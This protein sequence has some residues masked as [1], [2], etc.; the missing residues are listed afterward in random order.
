MTQISI[1]SEPVKLGSYAAPVAQ[2]LDRWIFVI[3][4]A[5]YIVV[6]LVGFIPDSLDQIA[7]VEAGKRPPFPP[8]LHAH[9]VLMGSFLLLLFGQSFLAATGRRAAHRKLGIAGAILALAL[10]VVG[11]LL[12][13]TMYHSLWDATQAMP[14]AARAELQQGLRDFENII[15]LQIRIG[16]LFPAFFILALAARKRDSGLHKR[17]MFL[18]VAMALPAAFDR[19]QWLPT[20]LPGG[21]LTTDLYPLLALA[22]MFVWDVVRTRKIHKAYLIWLA[23]VAPTSLL[24]H[25]LWDVEWWHATVPHL[26]G[27]RTRAF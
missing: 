16:V 24:V 11:F 27:V 6:T 23:I 20:S 2:L 10:V 19:M 13:P 5:W 22:P 9:A 14:S 7:A 15:L 21:P 18:A 4:A 25:A 3:M 26:I 1:P 12:V 8:V 17:M